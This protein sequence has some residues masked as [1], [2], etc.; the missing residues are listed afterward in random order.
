MVTSGN[1]SR[2]ELSSYKVFQ[3]FIFYERDVNGE[4]K[5]AAGKILSKECYDLWLQSRRKPP[6]KPMEAFRRALTAHCR[7]VD[8]RRPFPEDVEISLLKELRKKKR[9][10]C[11]KDCD[12]SVGLIGVQGF[13]SKGFHEKKRLR[14]SE[15]QP[16]QLPVLGKRNLEGASTS[17]GVGAL[18]SVV[19]PSLNAALLQQLLLSKSL[20]YYPTYGLQPQVNFSLYPL[21]PLGFGGN[22]FPHI[23]MN[24]SAPLQV[25]TSNNEHETDKPLEK[26]RK[27]E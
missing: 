26:K 7:G 19:T 14:Q 8:G 24:P 1:Q 27:T 5:C 9:W 10:E 21:L 23:S 25:D 12:E 16:V 3:K 18:G 6:K 15:G 2:Q 22:A 17:A 4:Q 11:F 13:P 20:L